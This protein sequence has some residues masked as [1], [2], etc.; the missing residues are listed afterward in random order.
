MLPTVGHSY[1]EFFSIAS[2]FLKLVPV[3]SQR[4]RIREQRE[5]GR[6]ARKGIALPRF[7]LCLSFE[8]LACNADR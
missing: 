4:K 7:F 1:T 8:P 3:Y 5:E 2:E 6:D